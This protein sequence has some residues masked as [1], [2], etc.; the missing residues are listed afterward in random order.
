MCWL[1]NSPLADLGVRQSVAGEPRDLSF[2]RDELIAGLD[3]AC[4]DM[5][6]G[7]PPAALTPQPLAVE[8]VGAG[9]M[10]AEACGPGMLDRLV[11]QVV[12]LGAVAFAGR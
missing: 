2:L 4:A 9:E 6:P 3:G 7:F 8:E 1:M 10:C 12:G 5:L 11:I